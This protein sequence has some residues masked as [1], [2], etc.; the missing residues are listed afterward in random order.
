M[1]DPESVVSARGASLVRARLSVGVCVTE[2]PA[3][4][5]A[6]VDQDGREH[7]VPCLLQGAGSTTSEATKAFWREWSAWC[8]DTLGRRVTLT[9]ANDIWE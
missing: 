8:A 7:Y 1:F 5:V 9:F 2:N 6:L 4:A 3:G